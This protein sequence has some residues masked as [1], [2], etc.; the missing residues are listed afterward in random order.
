MLWRRIKAKREAG[1]ERYGE[2]IRAVRAMAAGAEGKALP[3]L[4][5]QGP[6]AHRVRA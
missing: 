2:H 3:R 5:Q 1:C 6:D 4:R